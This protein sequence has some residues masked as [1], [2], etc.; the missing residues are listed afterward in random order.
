MKAVGL[1]SRQSYSRVGDFHY[2]TLLTLLSFSHLDALALKFSYS[3]NIW[4]V[5]TKQTVP[6]L[7]LPPTEAISVVGRNYLGMNKFF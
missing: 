2:N 4:R 6:M 3:L 5:I 7:Y 1:D